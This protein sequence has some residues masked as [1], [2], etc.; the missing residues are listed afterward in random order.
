M[1]KHPLLNRKVVRAS[2]LLASRRGNITSQS[3]VNTLNLIHKR[4]DLPKELNSSNVDYLPR[5]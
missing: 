2:V 5:L 4:A 3:K 1:A